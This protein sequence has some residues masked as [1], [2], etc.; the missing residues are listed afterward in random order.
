MNNPG[1]DPEPELE[2]VGG[3]G[4]TLFLKY[5]KPTL[6]QNFVLSISASNHF[7]TTSL[8]NAL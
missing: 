8:M 1:L 7:L 4:H 2:N 3:V 6:F 5:S